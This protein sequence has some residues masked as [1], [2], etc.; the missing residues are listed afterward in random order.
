MGVNQGSLYYMLLR[1]Y[2]PPQSLLL[3]VP[4]YN[5]HHDASVSDICPAAYRLKEATKNT[6]HNDID[7][8]QAG[9]R[10]NAWTDNIK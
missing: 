5:A 8:H 10:Q 9:E 7:V 2:M 6:M 3:V 1:S 4:R